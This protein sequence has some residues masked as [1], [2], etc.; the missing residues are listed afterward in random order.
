VGGSFSRDYGFEQGEEVGNGGGASC[1]V[2][3]QGAEDGGL[4]SWRD[5]RPEGSWEGEVAE[6]QAAG[7]H[8]IQE[9]PEGEEVGA[10]VGRKAGELFGGDVT[11]G[12]GGGTGL[13]EPWGI[14]AEG[15]G[16]S[17]VGD[18]DPVCSIKEDVLGLEIAMDDSR[19]V[20]G[21]D[22]IGDL[23]EQGEGEGDWEAVG[24]LAETV[25]EVAAFG[26]FHDDHGGPVI[27][28]DEVVDGDEVGVLEACEQSGLAFETLEEPFLGEVVAVD[29]LGGDIALEAELACEEDF[30]HAAFAES[31]EEGISG[32][33]GERLGSWRG[34]GNVETVCEKRGGVQ[35]AQ[36]AWAS[37]RGGGSGHGNEGRRN[38]A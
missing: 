30:A 15:K 3:V 12:A 27:E 16:H 21:G 38:G 37:R 32:N 10:G 22:G 35:P 36:P 4:D 26:E 25:A 2:W 13:G 24:M 19:E 31:F 8:L 1:R 34:L 23:V 28:A 6:R 18:Q 33:D 14:G 11:R 7:E 9:D 29:D 20:G 5:F 17:E